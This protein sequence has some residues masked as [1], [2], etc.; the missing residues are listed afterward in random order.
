LIIN[1]PEGEKTQGGEQ[2]M[3]EEQTQEKQHWIVY[4]LG[5][6]PK[7]GLAVLLGIQQY[8]TMFGATVLIPFIVGG[9]MGLPGDQ[10]ALMILRT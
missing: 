10:L 8:L 7:W 9:A 6:K 4:P 3:S 1:P 2:I 5:S